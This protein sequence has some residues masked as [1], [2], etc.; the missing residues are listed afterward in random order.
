MTQFMAE[1]ETFAELIRPIAAG[2]RARGIADAFDMM[3][4]AAVLI[5]GLGCVLHAGPRATRL[6]GGSLRLVEGHSL[7]TDP[8]VDAALRQL[9]AAVAGPLPT[10]IAAKGNAVDGIDGKQDVVTVHRDNE[11]SVQIRAMRVPQADEGGDQ[12]L[13]AV[14]VVS[15]LRH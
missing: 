15:E 14:L 4:V 1:D 12:L 6:L 7:G 11:T 13:R 3:G 10:D 8:A 2:A 5:D 9:I